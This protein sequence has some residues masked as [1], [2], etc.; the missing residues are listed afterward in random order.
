[1]KLE[2]VE[3]LAIGKISPAPPGHRD[4]DAFNSIRRIEKD[5]IDRSSLI[6]MNTRVGRTFEYEGRAC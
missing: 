5:R 6:E 4:R 3:R 2:V 1:V